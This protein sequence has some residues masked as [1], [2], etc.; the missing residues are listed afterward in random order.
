MFTYNLNKWKIYEKYNN[1]KVKEGEQS[2]FL[3]QYACSG[4]VFSTY[5]MFFV[6]LVRIFLSFLILSTSFMYVDWI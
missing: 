6:R 4:P 3:N 2:R 1:Q 5:S